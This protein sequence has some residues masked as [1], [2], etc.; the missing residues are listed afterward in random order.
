MTK[1]Q[2]ALLQKTID[3]L[4]CNLKKKAWLRVPKLRFM[5]ELST[6]IIKKE[7]AKCPDDIERSIKYL[8][9]AF[10]NK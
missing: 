4:A 2:L 6:R 3:A 7:L 10:T 9:D 8:G 5:Y 1:I